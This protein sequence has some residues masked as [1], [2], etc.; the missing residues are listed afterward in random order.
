VGTIGHVLLF[1][2]IVIF[3]LLG[4]SSQ[5][6]MDDAYG[7]WFKGVTPRESNAQLFMR[8]LGYLA[9]GICVAVADSFGWRIYL[10]LFALLFFA[11]VF[12]IRRRRRDAAGAGPA[13]Q[14]PAAN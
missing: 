10:P 3:G 2:I 14:F 5:F 11:M 8:W 9:L 6:F 1:A 7:R 12:V 4:L 13:S